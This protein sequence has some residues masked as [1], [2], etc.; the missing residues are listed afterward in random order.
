MLTGKELARSTASH[1]N[2]VGDEVNTIL[3]T[4]RTGTLKIDWGVH[5]HLSSA[6]H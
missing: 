1:G 5:R 4:Q 3:I 2:F 6:L